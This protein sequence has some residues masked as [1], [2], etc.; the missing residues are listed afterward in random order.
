MP[1]KLY[2]SVSAS[3]VKAQPIPISKKS[4]AS[5]KV[6]EKAEALNIGYHGTLASN[7]PSIKKHGLRSD[8]LVTYLARTSE[9]ALMWAR[10]MHPGKK[11]AVI[12]VTHDRPVSDVI[13]VKRSIGPEEIVSITNH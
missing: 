9:M 8:G 5:L 6:F 12:E 13:Q 11:L 7:V 2:E 10:A 1:I 4:K 3:S